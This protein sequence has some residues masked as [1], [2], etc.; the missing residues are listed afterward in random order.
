PPPGTDLRRGQTSAGDR[1]PPGTD[2]RRITNTPCGSRVKDCKGAS[3]FFK[4]GAAKGH[5][6]IFFQDDPSKRSGA[7]KGLTRLYGF[8]FICLCVPYFTEVFFV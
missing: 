3:R 8:Q 7:L 1:P 5:P 2:L 4:T 6:G